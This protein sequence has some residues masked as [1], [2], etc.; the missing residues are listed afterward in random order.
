MQTIA[1]NECRCSPIGNFV[2]RYSLITIMKWMFTY[3][4]LCT[5]PFSYDDLM[6]TR[7]EAL[8]GRVLLGIL[9]IVVCV[10]TINLTT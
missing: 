4:F 3:A 1:Q 9:F 5:L 8:K 2:S 6:A 10:T 7:W